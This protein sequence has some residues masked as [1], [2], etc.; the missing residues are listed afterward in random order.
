[1]SSKPAETSAVDDDERKRLCDK[2]NEWKRR[3]FLVADAV[4][5]ES[6]SAEQLADIARQTRADLAT[7]NEEIA[8]LREA[9]LQHVHVDVHAATK[10]RL[11]R[12]CDLIR[13]Q[14]AA[15]EGDWCTSPTVEEM[16]AIL[17]DAESAQA[18]E[19][20]R[21]LE[22]VYEA[23]KRNRERHRWQDY[24]ILDKALAAVDARRGA[25]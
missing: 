20:W 19:A 22:A 7:A 23:A 2:I 9:C 16:N 10:A 11:G 1:M 21:E 24:A 12:A 18:G 14:V 4:A 6:E 17:T 15:I 3:Y 25:K 8:Q 13:R 5:R